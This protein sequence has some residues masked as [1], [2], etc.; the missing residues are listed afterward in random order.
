MVCRVIWGEMAVFGRRNC[1][2]GRRRSL[3][4][5][6]SLLVIAFI[7][8][9][10]V[11]RKKYLRLWTFSGATG[12]IHSTVMNRRCDSDSI[13]PPGLVVPSSSGFRQSAVLLAGS[14]SIA[15]P[16]LGAVKNDR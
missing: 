8:L 3:A 13:V 5:S 12:P 10:A 16:R 7:L 1:S 4:P 6:S 11:K 15:A 9:I 14:I 2:A